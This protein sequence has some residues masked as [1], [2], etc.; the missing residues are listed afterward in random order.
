MSESNN[1]EGKTESNSYEGGMRDK[2]GLRVSQ[3]SGREN[4]AVRDLRR[5]GQQAPFAESTRGFTSSAP[6]LRSCPSR[7][8]MIGLDFDVE[9]VSL[10]SVSPLNSLDVSRLFAGSQCNTGGSTCAV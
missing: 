6:C 2:E 7:A 10:E 3:G 5:F 8:T 1:M 4:F 9:G